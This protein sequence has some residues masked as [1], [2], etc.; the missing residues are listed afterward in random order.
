MRKPRAPCDAP[1]PETRPVAASPYLL[2][3]ELAASCLGRQL[4]PSSRLANVTDKQ[5]A[6]SRSRAYSLLLGLEEVSVRN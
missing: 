4:T 6:R 5:V 1:R 3:T 2:L